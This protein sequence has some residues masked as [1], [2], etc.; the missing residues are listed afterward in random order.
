[1][2][3]RVFFKGTFISLIIIITTE[4]PKTNS[5]SLMAEDTSFFPGLLPVV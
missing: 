4:I 1:M 2:T 3:R 5:L